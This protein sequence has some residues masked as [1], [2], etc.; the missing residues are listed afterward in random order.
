MQVRVDLV[1][2]IFGTQV[3]KK[4]R[5]FRLV[6]PDY[7]SVSY[8]YVVT[9]LTSCTAFLLDVRWAVESNHVPLF[10]SCLSSVTVHLRNLF[11]LSTPVT[12]MLLT[13]RWVSRRKDVK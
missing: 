3:I 1:L 8:D 9:N 5:P 13:S 4:K 11:L 2:I 12:R 10:C 7:L 6:F